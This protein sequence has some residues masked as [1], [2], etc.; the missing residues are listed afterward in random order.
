MGKVLATVAEDW[1]SVRWAG[2]GGGA[3]GGARARGGCGR[4]WSGGCGR[5]VLRHHCRAHLRVV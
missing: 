1:R 3:A 2:A 5:W 4:W